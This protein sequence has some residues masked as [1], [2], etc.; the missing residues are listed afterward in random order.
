MK[1]LGTGAGEGTPNPFCTC[2]VCENARKKKGK[3]I[4][5]RSSFLLSDSVIID[6]GADFFTQSFMYDADF[7][8][9]E[10]A[11]FTHMHDD[12]IN[13][14]AIWERLVR[15]SGGD[16]PLN[17]YFVGDAYK[18][19]EEF[20]LVSPL[21][22]GRE[23]YLEPGNVAVHKLEFNKEYSID[24]FSVTPVRAAHSTGFEKNGSNFF[25]RDGEKTLFY[26]VDTGYF[27]DDA[28]K[29]LKGSKLG[30]LICECTFPTTKKAADKN[31]EH[32]DINM[33]MKNL[34]ELR[35]IGAVT[36]ET[37][38]YVTHISP[39]GMTHEEFSRYMSEAD[40]NIKVAY[41]GMEVQRMKTRGIIFDKDGTLMDYKTFWIP[42]AKSAVEYVLRETGADIS[43]AEKMLDAIGMNDGILGILCYG[44][45]GEMAEM[46]LRVLKK[47][48][49]KIELKELTELTRRAFIYGSERG[50]IVPACDDLPQMLA[51]FK[52]SGMFLAVATTDGPTITEKCLKKL[53]IYEYFDK[54]YADDGVH[55]P[56]PNAYYISDLC[57]DTGLRPDELV[58]VGDTETDTEFA[59]NG[60]VKC[61]GV[62]KDAA[63][64]AIL[65]R[66]AACVIDDISQLKTVLT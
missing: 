31:S 36:P 58:M 65:S 59:E 11:L 3:E 15:R 23:E 53:G 18:Y 24:R 26:A 7:S 5:T 22:A 42:A 12:H 10:H 63:D 50:K 4:R 55:P 62:A 16:K 25:I 60:S 61:I 48:G 56:K 27:T 30:T 43:L 54:I 13:Y 47:A 14:T 29:L 40:A 20:Y 45:Y 8:K 19:M 49:V 39:M 51:D 1:F 46:F 64:K 35:R 38:I 21:T 37:K 9:L 57:A 34:D 33:F 41:D 2:R 66:S 17:L 28:F 6:I 44:T 52:R 32:M